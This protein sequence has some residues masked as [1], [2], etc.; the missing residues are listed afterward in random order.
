MDNNYD[1]QSNIDNQNIENIEKTTTITEE[2]TISSSEPQKPFKEVFKQGSPDDVHKKVKDV[3][4]KGVAAVAGALKGFAD[5]TEKNDVAGTT[6]S[7]IQQAGETTRTTVSSVTD[8]VKSLKEPLKEAGQRLSETAKSLKST[9]QEQV[10]NTKQAVK[11][12]STGVGSGG[13][14]SGM[15]MSTSSYNQQG[16]LGGS[17]MGSGAIGSGMTGQGTELPDISKTPL[18]QSDKKLQGKDLSK[19]YD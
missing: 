16:G 19:K 14:S 4:Q 3:V 2:T 6:K 17:T 7:A 11:G 10:Q 5:Q 13:M 8:E 9:A 1:N 15:D 18:S 12:S